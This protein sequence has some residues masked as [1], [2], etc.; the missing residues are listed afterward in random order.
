MSRKYPTPKP[1]IPSSI[2]AA[3]LAG[4][5][6]LIGVCAYLWF[7]TQ[8]LGEDVNHIAAPGEIY[9]PTWSQ[10]SGARPEKFPDEA[11]EPRDRLDQDVTEERLRGQDGE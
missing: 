8:R 9:P 3:T 5:L 11:A 1:G 4:V 2:R 10:R 7:V 6:P